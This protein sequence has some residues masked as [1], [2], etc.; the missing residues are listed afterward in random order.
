MPSSRGSSQ[1]RAQTHVPWSSCTAGE[2]I[3]AE[4][5]GKSIWMWELDIKEGWMLKN[6]RFWSLLP[7]KTLESPLD[8]KEIKSVNPKGNQ[9]WVFNGRSVAEAEEPVLGQLIQSIDSLE[10]TLMMENIEGKRRRE[11]Q[12]RIRW[13]DSITNSMGMNLSKIQEIVEDRGVLNAVHGV[14]NSWT[15]LSDWA[16]TT[17]FWFTNQLVLRDFSKNNPRKSWVELL[18]MSTI[19][20]TFCR[21]KNCTRWGKDE[22]STLILGVWLWGGYA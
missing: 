12:K 17:I 20:S 15:R 4:P 6:W 16:T 14:T 21:W 11:W 13:L 1:C 7:E 10:K 5:L 9:S 18:V 2:L 3:T 19:I 22:T 8:Y